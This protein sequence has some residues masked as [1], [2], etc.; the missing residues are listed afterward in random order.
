MRSKLPVLLLLPAMALFATFIAWPLVMVG[1]LSLHRSN[2]VLTEYVG[3]ANYA[4]LLRDSKWWLSIVNCLQY[5]AL[6]VP[7]ETGGAL[8]LSLLL[9][10][11]RKRIQ[12]VGRFVFFVPTLAAGVILAKTWRWM[13][14]TDGLVNW[15][16]SLAHLGPFTFLL[17]RNSGIA[18]VA[19]ALILT[20][21][22]SYIVLVLGSMLSVGKDVVEAATIDGA[23][24]WQIKRKIIM[25]LIAPTLG[26]VSLLV[27]LG[28]MQMWETARF[29]TAGAPNG[30]TA[31]MTMNIVE[32][33][34]VRGDYGMA[35]AKGVVGIAIIMALSL[36]KRRAEG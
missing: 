27:L 18:A 6:M 26:L 32:E 34:F 36:I 35:A 5:A 12:D 4:K 31:T 24:P 25:P 2:Y 3:F 13:F 15:F 11:N 14:A 8:L 20:S 19:V 7:F 30:G 23:S 10:D 29:M 22:G 16:L 28:A 17:E 33:G 1:Q 21:T 9:F